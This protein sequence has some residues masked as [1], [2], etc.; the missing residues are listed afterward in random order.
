LVIDRIVT[1]V[2]STV[3]EDKDMPLDADGLE[4]IKQTE[5]FFIQLKQNLMFKEILPTK[6]ETS[7]EET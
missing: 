4:L 6:E 5:S 7:D 2:V 3:E 1:E